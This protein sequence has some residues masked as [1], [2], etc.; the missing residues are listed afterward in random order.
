MNQTDS[1]QGKT[2]NQREEIFNK[3]KK[4]AQ[5]SQDRKSRTNAQWESFITNNLN[6][7]I[8]M[9]CREY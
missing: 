4:R 5:K 6:G 1:N 8:T 9:E 3:D 2:K 7:K